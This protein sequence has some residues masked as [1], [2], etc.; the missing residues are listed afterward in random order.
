MSCLIILIVGPICTHVLQVGRVWLVP[1]TF[2]FHVTAGVC[3]LGSKRRSCLGMN[4]GIAYF[5]FGH[6]G[7]LCWAAANCV[8]QKSGCNSDTAMVFLSCGE[9][10]LS[11]SCAKKHHFRQYIR[12]VIRLYDRRVAFDESCIVHVCPGSFLFWSA[13]CGASTLCVVPD[14]LDFRSNLHSNPSSWEFV[15]FTMRFLINSDGFGR[16]RN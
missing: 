3:I 15:P 8:F 13:L 14:L 5:C 9:T 11:P 7:N 4:N 12:P 10:E 16:F 1:L 2:L 6:C